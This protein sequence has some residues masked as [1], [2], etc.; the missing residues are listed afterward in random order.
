MPTICSSLSGQFIE[1][2]KNH[3]THLNN[4]QLSDCNVNNSDLQIDVPI[5]ADHYWDFMTGEV[6][7]G[8]EGPTKHL[9]VGFK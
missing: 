7:R 1:L 3:Y 4:I 6:K 9:R 8:S 2:A 5:R